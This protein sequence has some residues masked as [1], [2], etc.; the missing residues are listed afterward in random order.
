V[1]EGLRRRVEG[2]LWALLILLLPLTSLPLLSRLAGGTMVAPAAIIPLVLLILI[3]LI[4]RLLGGMGL[5]RQVLPLLALTLAAAVSCGLSLF[6]D[7]PLFRDIDR[8]SNTLTALATSLVG[9]GFYLLAIS[10]PDSTDKLSRLYFWLNI[11]GFV[12][13]LWSG[14]QAIVWYAGGLYPEWMWKLQNM[15]SSSGNLYNQ[16]VTGLAFEPSWLGH[17]LV[18][19]YLPYW[20]AAT[21][22]RSS[23]FRFRLW[24]WTAEN[25]LLG[26][27]VGVLFLAFSRSAILSFLLASSWLLV[28]LAGK[29][30]H[31]IQG[32]LLA[33]TPSRLQAVLIRAAI[34]AGMVILA[35]AAIAGLIFA[36]T[37]LDSRM[38]DLFSLLQRRLSF[39]ELA[40]QLVFGERVVFWNAGLEVFGDH[41]VFG[42]GLGNAGFF[43]P[44]KLTAFGWTVAEPFKMVYSTA[45]PNTLSLW[46]RLLAET[47]LLGFSLFLSWLVILWK[48]ARY[49]QSH[50]NSILGTAG[51]AGQLAMIALL[52]EGM[53]VDTLALPYFWL[54]FGW[55]TAAAAI[56]RRSEPSG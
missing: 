38:A 5:P 22:R 30:V 11:S 17:Q 6:L 31:R 13:I 1:V 49:I 39:T 50:T 44:E 14:L 46:V 10:W 24:K 33:D 48:S 23:A 25:V 36:A 43:F 15:I 29:L 53:S 20:L 56:A 26:L 2:G 42:V 7:I 4:P 34:W 21:I 28:R 18:L 37:R 3:F 32:K 9:V 45:L 47:G 52:M 27:G 40:Y 16:R 35:A 41:P 55:L 51:L 19:L 12:I 8:L 54:S